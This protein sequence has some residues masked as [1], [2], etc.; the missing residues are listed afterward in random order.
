MAAK[1]V[2]PEVSDQTIAQM[3]DLAEQERLEYMQHAAQ[4]ETAEAEQFRIEKEALEKKLGPDHPRVLALE[5]VRR[6]AEI[7][8]SFA[9][10]IRGYAEF[11]A[12]DAKVPFTVIPPKEEERTGCLVALKRAF[13]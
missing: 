12:K 3:T 4:A 1:D 10:T 11:G 2:T 13:R 8:A 7:V 5:D 9:T 6:S